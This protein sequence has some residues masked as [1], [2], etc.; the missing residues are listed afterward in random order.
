MTDNPPLLFLDIDGVM[1]KR[2]Q[3]GLLDT[4]E[5]APGCLEFLEWATMRF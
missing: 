5:L 2:R 3:W 4:F 1:L